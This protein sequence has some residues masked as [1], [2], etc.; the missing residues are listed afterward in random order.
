M[1]KKAV[2]ACFTGHRLLR[3]G[4]R[5]RLLTWLPGLIEGLIVH[6]GF[7]YFGIGGAIGFD[8]LAADCVLAI[9]KKYPHVKLIMV[10]PCKNQT[11]KWSDTPEVCHYEDVLSKADKI[12]YTSQKYESRCYTI[13]NRHLVY[14]SSLVIAYHYYQAG[15]GTGQTIRMAQEANLEIINLA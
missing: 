2:T 14:C 13:R 15:S 8:L 3:P 4:D 6:R 5:D 9:K 12:V 11:Q 10:L 1:D 7:R